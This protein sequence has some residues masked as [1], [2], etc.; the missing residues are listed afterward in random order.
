MANVP[1]PRVRLFLD[2]LDQITGLQVVECRAEEPFEAEG[3]RL[4]LDF[5]VHVRLGDESRVTA[6]GV[7]AMDNV[8]PRD[9]QMLTV[10]F[11]ARATYLVGIDEVP[12]VVAT[13]LSDGAKKL[14]RDG[15]V[16]FYE[17]ASGTLYFKHGL[18]HIDI[19]R[20]G[21]GPAE[22]KIRSVFNGAREQVVHALLEHWRREG[23]DAWVSGTDLA[24]MAETS[25]F[26]VSTT[27][28]EL[29]RQAWVDVTGAG[30]TLR[31]RLS[32]PENLLD[33]WAQAWRQKLPS[34]KRTRWYAYA[35]G[36]SG[37]LDHMLSRLADFDGW[38]LTGAGAANTV[39]PHLT[40]VDRVSIIVPPGLGKDWADDLKLEPAEKGANVTFI[41]RTGASLM[42][43]DSHPDRPG[44][45]FA[46][47]FVMYLDLLDGVGRNKELATEFRSRALG[48]GAMVDG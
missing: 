1:D 41:E 20:E 17:V 3:K 45:R 34:E 18:R 24:E 21:S 30:P 13:Y 39:V 2:A 10:R 22:R 28:Q 16:N 32:R 11:A 48:L 46:S 31:R 47:R 15:D 38:A 5:L 25:P 36:R 23:G 33:A 7:E 6:L 8:Y 35:N 42:F 29:E 40:A 43:G 27:L 37:I 44:S 26:T 12:I 19:Q 9:A 14:L 4:R